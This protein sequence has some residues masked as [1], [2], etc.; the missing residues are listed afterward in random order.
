[1]GG[2]KKLAVIT[3]LVA[4]ML[5]IFI[6]CS[7]EGN[8]GAQN[9]PSGTNSVGK[10]TASP[11]ETV[12]SQEGSKTS[13]F[14]PGDSGD[15]GG[16]KALFENRFTEAR[17]VAL[18]YTA[19][20][21]RAEGGDKL[22]EEGEIYYKCGHYSSKAELRAATAAVFTTS[23]AQ[24]FYKL[25]ES[26]AFLDKD[27]SLYISP[28]ALFDT[29]PWQAGDTISFGGKTVDTFVWDSLR[30][31]MAV[32]SAVSYTLDWYHTY[33]GDPVTSSF[34]LR[35]DMDGIWRFDR[36]FSE[37]AQVVLDV[38]VSDGTVAMTLETADGAGGGR[39]VVPAT[40]CNGPNRVF[41]LESSFNWSYPDNGQPVST[42]SASSLTLETK[43]G[44]ASIQCWHGSNLV[45]CTLKGKSYWLTAGALKTDMFDSSIFA[46]LRFWYDEAEMDSLRGGIVIPNKGQSYEEIAEEWSE[47]DEGAMLRATPGSK[48]ACTYV[49]TTAY[50]VKEAMDS[51]FPPNA[52][53]SKHFYFRKSTVFVP[54]NETARGWLMAGNT[55]DY[56]G[57]DA[58]AGAF[59]YSHGG[60]MYLTEDGWRCDGVGTGP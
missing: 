11:E 15:P 45:F 41:N 46:Y 36:C 16:Y 5:S 50:V 44:T 51:W 12:S 33:P 6:G 39:Y 9:S 25:L 4:L 22:S 18:H 49:I 58:P 10:Y 21:I 38:I 13:H 27:G 55:I 43:D 47:A 29:S 28:S 24:G 31:A 35:K 34:S 8:S 56:K 26:K 54:E 7:G 17:K 53:N 37:G 3:T 52:L 1:M 19:A 30:V 20:F 59:K 60:P 57:N 23:C 40:K 14:P 42:N 2:L 32:N 48:Y